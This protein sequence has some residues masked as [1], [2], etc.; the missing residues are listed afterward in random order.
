MWLSNSN[1][2]LLHLSKPDLDPAY[3]FL[4]ELCIICYICIIRII[5][6]SQRGQDACCV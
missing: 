5:R 3:K 4:V 1:N 6:Y 2:L